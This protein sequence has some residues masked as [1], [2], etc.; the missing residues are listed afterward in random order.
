LMLLQILESMAH[1]DNYRL[2]AGE[3]YRK[4][5]HDFNGD[6]LAK[7]MHYINVSYRRKI[8]LGEV[9]EIANLHPAAFSRFFKEKTGKTFIHFINN[10]RISYA[11]KLI[12]ENQLS[13][14]EVCYE[15]GFNNISNFNR[16]FKKQTGYTPT[17]YY[18]QFNSGL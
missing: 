7:V 3:L 11:C 4:S 6:R 5:I 13:V 16:T 9:S 10:M 17:E 2:L 12:I 14:S 18:D 15:S 8:E 1:T